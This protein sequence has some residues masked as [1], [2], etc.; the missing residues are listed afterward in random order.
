MRHGY[1]NGN[2][3][4]LI[5]ENTGTK[6]RV[7]KEDEFLPEFA[8]SIDVALTYECDGGCPFCYADCT[9]DG[10]HTDLLSENVMHFVDSLKPFTELALN[11]N[12][13]SIPRLEAFLHILKTKRVFTNITVNQKHFAKNIDLLKRWTESNLIYGLGVSLNDPH[14]PSIKRIHEFPNA[15][16]HTVAGI[17]SKEDLKVLKGR[18]FKI[19][20]LGYK[21]KGRGKDFYSQEIEEKITWLGNHICQI[22][23][24]EWFDVVSFD[25]LALSQLKIK[26]KISQEEWERFYMGDDGAF[27]FFVDLVN[28]VFANDSLTEN[29]IPITE[30]N[31]NKMFQIIQNQRKAKVE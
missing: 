30:W 9:P 24:E 13:L 3:I 7:T 29:V 21:Q 1:K 17:L 5:D 6:I 25:N 22:I 27:T 8:E 2:Y 26:D 28:E 16:I 15:V 10:R 12:D 18:D 20:I 19:L 31:A 23:D 4:V 14:D 11:G